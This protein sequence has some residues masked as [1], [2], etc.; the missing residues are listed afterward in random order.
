MLALFTYE[1][2]FAWEGGARRFCPL[3]FKVRVFDAP[4]VVVVQL[5]VF[6]LYTGERRWELVVELVAVAV[7]IDV[8]PFPVVVVDEP[9]LSDGCNKHCEAKT[10]RINQEI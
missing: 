5:F 7:V 10:K 4:P 1:F 9:L 3:L 8:F 2:V 6:V